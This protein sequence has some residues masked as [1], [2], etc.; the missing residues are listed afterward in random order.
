[1]AK[2]DIIKKKKDEVI[3]DAKIDGDNNNFYSPKIIL[4]TIL[5]VVVL[6]VILF[7]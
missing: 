7:L 2:K 6:F 4:M 1:M 3:Y 5:F